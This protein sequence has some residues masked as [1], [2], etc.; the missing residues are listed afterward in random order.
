V[1]LN[2]PE[3]SVIIPTIGRLDQLRRTLDSIRAMNG[4]AY[5]VIVVDQS[6]GADVK[7]LL[8]ACGDERFRLLP[9]EGRGRGRAV[10]CGAA[11]SCG[12]YLAIT[13]D[14]VIVG[15]DWLK[16]ALRTFECRKP[17]HAVVGRIS[18]YGEKPSEEYVDPQQAEWPEEQA[19][20]ASGLWKGFGANQFFLRSAWDKVDGMDPRLGTG[21][22]CG[23]SD[24]W[25]VLYRMLVR[26]MCV[27]YSPSV[28]IW[29]DG[30]ETRAV[31][32]A[33]ARRYDRARM[34]AHIK[35]WFEVG[36]P[37]LRDMAALTMRTFF[38]GVEHLAHRRSGTAWSCFRKFGHY[39]SGVPLGLQLAWERRT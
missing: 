13:D 28:R 20:R 30:W 22:R 33:K 39:M 3:F 7:S 36:G 38:E 24:D 15:P 17:C 19:L 6:G 25:D 21:G 5:E 31:R 35:S 14:D 23:S 4:P 26:G 32:Q 37:A 2:R 11:Q 8:A 9:Q 34:A 27:W 16:S 18:P 1:L 12:R 29:H 10:G